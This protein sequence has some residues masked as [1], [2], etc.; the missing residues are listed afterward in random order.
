MAPSPYDPFHNIIAQNISTEAPA[1]EINADL[2]EVKAVLP[3]KAFVVSESSLIVLHLGDK[4]WRGYVSRVSPA[5]SSI[6]FSLEE[7]GIGRKLIKK[8]KFD[9]R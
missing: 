9:K 6:E 3:G 5:E 8:I 7:G 4:V 2:V 1:G